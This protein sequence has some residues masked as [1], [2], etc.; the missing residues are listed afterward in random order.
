MHFKTVR[1]KLGE[2]IF[3]NLTNLM[4]RMNGKLRF[5]SQEYEAMR[6]TQEQ[7]RFLLAQIEEAK[8]EIQASGKTIV[9]K[10]PVVF[11]GSIAACNV[12]L[13]PEIHQEFVLG[14]VELESL[15]KLNGSHININ[16]CIVENQSK[17]AAIHIVPS[18]EE[19]KKSDA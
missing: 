17:E 12:K 7:L 15:L 16:N 13:Q 18:T 9:I 6:K 3:P 4:L 19:S 8:R 5:M 2:F 1:R 11:L 14:R 10:G